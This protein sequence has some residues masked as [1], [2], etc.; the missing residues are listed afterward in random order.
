MMTNHRC[1]S[2]QAG[3]IS[4]RLETWT[5]VSAHVG[6]CA[7]H[8]LSWNASETFHTTLAGLLVANSVLH[9]RR[10]HLGRTERN[11]QPSQFPYVMVAITEIEDTPE[12][13]RGDDAATQLTA[14]LQSL[15][16]SSASSLDEQH[17]QLLARVL[18]P[19]NSLHRDPTSDRSRALA[20]LVLS[21]LV[22]D[23]QTTARVS[24]LIS[25][26]I[27]AQLQETSIPRLLKGISFLDALLQV[28][29]PVKG[30]EGSV[31]AVTKRVLEADGLIES[32]VDVL[33]VQLFTADEDEKA[34]ANVS[35]KVTQLPSIDQQH[36]LLDRSLA[37]LF[38]S[39]ANTPTYRVI[40]DGRPR[41]W[42][43]QHL[44]KPSSTNQ[45]STET[46][47]T[48]AQTR[49]VAA[50]ALTKLAKA[51]I[52][53]PPLKGKTESDGGEND[54]EEITARAGDDLDRL[55]SMLKGVVIGSSSRQ[56]SS[57]DSTLSPDSVEEITSALEGLAYTSSQPALR[58]ALGKDDQFL[59]SL[60]GIAKSLSLPHRTSSTKLS[61][62]YG[63]DFSS[64]PSGPQSNQ[65]AAY[66][67]ATIMFNLFARRTV[68][69]EEQRQ[70]EALK[71]MANAGATGG[72]NKTM[73]Q[74]AKESNNAED[75][76]M[77]EE[78]VHARGQRGIRNGA[79]EAISALAKVDS[80][81]V[82]QVL[83][84][85]LLALVHEREDRLEIVK[86]GGY[87]TLKGIIA[88]L[89]DSTSAASGTPLDK[90][91]LPALQALA[92]LVITT[93]PPQLFGTDSPTGAMDT[94][95]PIAL[96]LLHPDSSMLQR[97]EAMMALTNL[98]S[99]DPSVAQRIYTFQASKSA[100]KSAAGGRGE[101]N[102]VNDQ[103]VQAVENQMLEDHKLVRRAAVELVCNLLISDESFARYSGDYIP[104]SNP[105]VTTPEQARKASTP[106][107]HIL[108][109]LTD[110]RDLP[111]RL[112]A[113]GALAMLTQ[114]DT[115]CNILLGLGGDSKKVWEKAGG[116][117]A[118][119]RADQAATG[120]EDFEDFGD[121][122]IEELSTLPPDEGL[123]YRGLTIVHNLFGCVEKLSPTDK[124]AKIKEADDSSLTRH[125]INLLAIWTDKSLL[126]ANKV[127]SPPREVLDLGIE[128]L[129]ILKSNGVQLVA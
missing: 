120:D 23:L 27:L 15:S 50:V 21:R 22:T 41:T 102:Q 81:R 86:Q 60:F 110:V 42:L 107:L 125:L 34:T 84:S 129:R 48:E 35:G 14:L 53:D 25:A 79:V 59:G 82:K 3:P 54:Q 74:A 87:K 116:L 124:A 19:L 85:V 31:G 12:E 67:I 76:S 106:R 112:A 75:E 63:T 55:T 98:A 26:Y 69:T 113:S 36:A 61:A 20:F 51:A 9:K 70:V 39:M 37:Q 89:L 16:S 66:G 109:A 111:T 77:S 119:L 44:S 8:V 6:Q 58:E 92:K 115:A 28:D 100:A 95:R 64:S 93:P 33:D 10:V 114:S 24:T 29:S 97:F 104:G 46:A 128:C 71:K 126:M 38:S 103:I 72:K 49:V 99:V 30:G 117:L 56:S 1:R 127:N 52:V 2:S 62:S 7:F 83:G 65:A 108:L 17:L 94:V 40:L 122:D 96:L 78:A 47:A 43:E 45:S 57:S 80:L 73:G 32:L 121:D 68:L 4:S 105:S 118:P 90:E 101:A 18:S 13:P 11:A 5:F 91:C 88:S 123:V